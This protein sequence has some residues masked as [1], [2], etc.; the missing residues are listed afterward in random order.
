MSNAGK[1]K[2][3]VKPG[4][5]SREELNDYTRA[6]LPRTIY[7]TLMDLGNLGAAATD[8]QTSFEEVAIGF[9]DELDADNH[10]RVFRIDFDVETNA[11]ESIRDV[12][13]DCVDLIAAGEA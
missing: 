4:D 12:T 3:G 2:W 10:P 6:V 11:P 9:F 8:P 7:I 1:I 13:A 5:M